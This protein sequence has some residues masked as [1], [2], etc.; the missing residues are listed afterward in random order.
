MDAVVKT[1]NWKKN[2]KPHPHLCSKHTGRET[3][4]KMI[5]KHLSQKFEIGCVI[6]LVRTVTQKKGEKRKDVSAFK[7]RTSWLIKHGKAS[8][9]T[10]QFRVLSVS[11]MTFLQ[12]NEFPASSALLRHI[13]W[14]LS[15]FKGLVL[16]T[17]P[18]LIGE[19]LVFILSFTLVQSLFHMRSR[20]TVCFY[21]LKFKSFKIE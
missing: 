12:N 21:L 17:R 19:T 14:D 7:I 4:N 2:T 15:F 8:K 6:Y 11:L 10:R 9:V 5:K 18:H 20:F 16:G 3:I 13:W 1:E